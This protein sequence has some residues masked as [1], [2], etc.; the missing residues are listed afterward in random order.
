MERDETTDRRRAADECFCQSPDHGKLS[1]ERMDG[2][3]GYIQG[4]GQ[5]CGTQRFDKPA[6]ERAG[7]DVLRR[8]FS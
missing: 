8:R 5:H 1:E 6:E 4:E 7:R 2:P 3:E